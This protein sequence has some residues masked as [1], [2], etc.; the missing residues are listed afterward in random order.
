MKNKDVVAEVLSDVKNLDEV[1][2]IPG[3]TVSY[4]FSLYNVGG[5]Y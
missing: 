3:Q 1:P 2:L 5:A 4:N